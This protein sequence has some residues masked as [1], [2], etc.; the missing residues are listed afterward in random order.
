MRS[1]IP[2]LLLVL[3]TGFAGSNLF[4]AHGGLN[5]GNVST[6]SEARPVQPM[7]IVMRHA[8]RLD[9]D[10]NAV[11]E[12]KSNPPL[13]ATA[14][15]SVKVVVNELKE[16]VGAER[17]GTCRIVASPFLRTR[18]TLEL[19]GN[20][21]VGASFEYDAQLCEVFG[22]QRIRT[23]QPKTV[24]MS[25]CIGSLPAWSETM[26]KAIDRY[27]QCFIKYCEQAKDENR[28]II[29]VTHGDAPYAVV[30]GLHPEQT[31]YACGYL[32]FIA[33]KHKDMRWVID[34]AHPRVEWMEMEG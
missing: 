18:Q 26:Q 32:G 9:D 33:A 20:N 16:L 27:Q 10:P 14:E 34:N 28:V 5:F 15:E 7:V 31:I 21:G 2:V 23:G 13:A 17:L 11:M 19:L 8:E 25:G 3:A 1:V 30:S 22:P 4:A 24:E 29:L 6:A 12:D